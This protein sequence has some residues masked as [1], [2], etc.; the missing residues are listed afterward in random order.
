MKQNIIFGF[1]SIFAMLCGIGLL[2]LKT[3]RAGA[4]KYQ[5][6]IPMASLYQYK[7]LDLLPQ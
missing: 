5:K 1:L 2:F 6:L 4:Q 7:W 3:E